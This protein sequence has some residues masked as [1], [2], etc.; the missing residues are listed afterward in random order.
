[1]GFGANL[2]IVGNCSSSVVGFFLN[3]LIKSLTSNLNINTYINKND[4][5]FDDCD[6][7]VR[8]TTFLKFYVGISNF[9]IETCQTKTEIK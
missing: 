8:L 2:H 9:Q 5:R 6:F 4:Q 7:F 1:M 3:T